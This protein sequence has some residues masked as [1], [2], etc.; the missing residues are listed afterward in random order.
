M[1]SIKDQL[2]EYRAKHKNSLEERVSTIRQQSPGGLAEPDSQN[3]A[4]ALH[5]ASAETDPSVHFSTLTVLS[6]NVDGLDN[7]FTKTRARGLVSAMLTE[8]PFAAMLQEV[9]QEVERLLKRR[10]S[11][12]YYMVTTKA[13]NRRANYYNMLLLARDRV[14]VTDSSTLWFPD[15]CMARH[16]LWVRAEVS[17][18][19]YSVPMWL[20]TSHLESL[21]PHS[22][23]RVNQLKICMHEAEAAGDQGRLVVLGGDL[24]LR[25]RE[26]KLAVSGTPFMDVWGLNGA[27][28]SAKFTWDTENN[29]NTDMSG[30]SYRP[31]MRLDRVYTLPFHHACFHVHTSDFRLLGTTVLP[32][33]ELFISDHFGV[34]FD[35]GVSHHERKRLRESVNSSPVAKRSKTVCE[36]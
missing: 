14:T 17:L 10:L 27:P 2:E 31:R 18:E 20:G 7:R 13:C 5:R 34:A 36:G 28:E 3:A 25:E 23:E 9:N 32:D 26:A 1:R 30:A 24:N 16:L 8:L 33:I 35:M 22:E 21:G 4:P 19:S 29:H 6:W 15:S 12:K 11:K